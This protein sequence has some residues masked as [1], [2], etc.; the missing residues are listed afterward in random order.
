MRNDIHDYKI[1]LFRYSDFE[2]G[3]L[4]IT[5]EN[6]IFSNREVRVNLQP[7]TNSLFSH[8]HGNNEQGQITLL[9]TFDHISR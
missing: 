5:L 7:M 3:N 1:W 6:I 2:T 8:P 4:I 9:D